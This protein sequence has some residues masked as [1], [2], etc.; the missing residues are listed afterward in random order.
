[1]EQ[2]GAPSDGEPGRG[3]PVTCPWCESENVERIGEF[4]PGLM[5]EQWMCLRCRS[6]FE[7]I[8]KR[9]PQTAC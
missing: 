1:M 6:P 8:R 2:P 4:G 7:L 3:E 5:T 9:S